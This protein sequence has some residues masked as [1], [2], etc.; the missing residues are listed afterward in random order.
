MKKISI[1]EFQTLFM[2][3]KERILSCNGGAIE[4]CEAYD[5]INCPTPYS[6]CLKNNK[7][8]ILLSCVDSVYVESFEELFWMCIQIHCIRDGKSV[9][10]CEI[11]LRW[12]NF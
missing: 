3:A 8:H 4:V 6:V 12:K 1:S 7:G 11:L 9:K 2:S 10:T 5:E